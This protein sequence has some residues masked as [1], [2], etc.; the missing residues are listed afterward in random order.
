MFEFFIFLCRWPVFLEKAKKTVLAGGDQGANTGS[1]G[2]S[3]TYNLASGP[4]RI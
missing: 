4:V 2:K 3:F 1:L